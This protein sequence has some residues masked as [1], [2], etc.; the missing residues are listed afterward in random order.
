MEKE[1]DVKKIAKLARLKLDEA[2]VAKFE[3]DLEEVKKMFDEID[4]L[5][6]NEEPCFQP[7]E[8]KNVLREDKTKKGFSLEDAFSNTEHR[9]K[10]FFKGPKV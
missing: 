2:E 1:I 3:R 7:V 5:E 8:V 4:K 9:E 6:V 10:D